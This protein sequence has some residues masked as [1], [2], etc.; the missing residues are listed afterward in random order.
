MH[1]ANEFWVNSKTRGE[2]P[3]INIGNPSAKPEKPHL[4]RKTSQF[5]TE[6]KPSL[7]EVKLIKF[8]ET[9]TVHKISLKNLPHGSYIHRFSECH[10]HPLSIE[11][12]R[13]HF[14]RQPHQKPQDLSHDPH[15]WLEA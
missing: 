8:Y 13:E 9:Q 2:S 12:Q 7:D 14:A 6:H 11:H 4:P 15:L 5:S 10:T 1:T 3:I